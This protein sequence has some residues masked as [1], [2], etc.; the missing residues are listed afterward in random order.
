MFPY[1]ETFSDFEARIHQV[2][3]RHMDQRLTDAEKRAIR[4]GTFQKSDRTAQ[5]PIED[6]RQLLDSHNKQWISVHKLEE[7]K[8]KL[9]GAVIE[10][11]RQN[12]L[13]MG[14]ISALSSV[15]GAVAYR[16]VELW[17]R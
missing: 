5:Y 3:D 15:V 1:S 12:L 9:E 13:Y 16:C 11:R 2:C 6:Y 17:L 8:N 14:A 7:G 4:C 10:L